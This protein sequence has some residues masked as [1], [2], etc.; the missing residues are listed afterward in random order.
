MRPTYILINLS[1]LR[2]NF[3]QIRKRV[4]NSKVMAVVKADA[5]GH[6]MFECVKAYEELG[7]RGPDYYG[8]ALIE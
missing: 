1:N 7:M 2:Y 5:Y 8:V 4:K 3:L 6:G